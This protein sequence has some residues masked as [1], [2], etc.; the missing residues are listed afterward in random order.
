MQLNPRKKSNFKI[1]KFKL[2]KRKFKKNYP[3]KNTLLMFY[4]LFLTKVE[5]NKN[6]GFETLY[7][8]MCECKKKEMTKRGMQFCDFWMGK[9]G[10][11]KGVKKGRRGDRE[12]G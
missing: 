10:E 8:I 11:R 4:G 12:R 9:W 3:L 7:M 1:N 2:K 6:C 5:P